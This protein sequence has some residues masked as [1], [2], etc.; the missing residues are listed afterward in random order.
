MP[1]TF[2]NVAFDCTECGGKTRFQPSPETPKIACS[3]CGRVF[4]LSAAPDAEGRVE[5]CL[6][7]GCHELYVRKDFPQRLGLTIIVIGFAVSCIPWYFGMWYTTYAVLFSTAVADAALYFLTGNLL[8]CYRC[9]AEYRRA[10][11]L[12]GQEP[13]NLETHE[14]YRQMAHR[15]GKAG[16]GANATASGA[17]PERETASRVERSASDDT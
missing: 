10:A 16:V 11:K 12:D 6:L 2:L 9:R 17:P 13:F 3:Q 4:T 7:C 5:R 15:L 1:S 14:R 8:Q